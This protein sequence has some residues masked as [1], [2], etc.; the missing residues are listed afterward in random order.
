MKNLIIVLLVAAIA[1]ELIFS[2]KNYKRLVG[3]EHATV[4][5]INKT[6]QLEQLSASAYC[7]AVNLK[8]ALYSTN[9]NQ[10]MVW[11]YDSV[12]N[13]SIYVTNTELKRPLYLQEAQ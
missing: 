3:V 4:R 6:A 1:I 11:S 8:L 13:I 7:D 10:M 12:G 2:F 9:S 5:L